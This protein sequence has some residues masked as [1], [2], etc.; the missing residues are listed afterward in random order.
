MLADLRHPNCRTPR[1]TVVEAHSGSLHERYIFILR[2]HYIPDSTAHRVARW[3]IG[4]ALRSLEENELALEKQMV[5]FDYY[6]DLS[7]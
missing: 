7:E 2:S 4:R 3:T 5:L 6:K 1:K